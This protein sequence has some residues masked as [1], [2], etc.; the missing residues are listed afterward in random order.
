[1]PSILSKTPP[2]PGKISLVSFTF[3]LR[4]RNEINK[5]PNCEVMDITIVITNI[6]SKFSLNMLL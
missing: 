3:A 4:L 1:M 5:S 2:C 6:L